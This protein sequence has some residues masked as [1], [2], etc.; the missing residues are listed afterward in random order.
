MKRKPSPPSDVLSIPGTTYHADHRLVTWHPRGV[1]DDD[2]ADRVVEF[3]ESEERI[4]G[5][6]FNRFTDLSGLDRVSISLEHV[7][8]VAKRRKESYSGP[9]VRSAFYALRLISLT[10]GRMYQELM[11]KSFIEVGVFPYR[12]AAAEWLNAPEEV[13]MPPAEPKR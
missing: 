2:L 1:F 9:A 7:F 11:A 5:N 10:I 13:L 8:T 6:P 4:R 12:T 3:M